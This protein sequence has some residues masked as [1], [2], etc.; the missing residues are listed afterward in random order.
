MWV[1]TAM[2]YQ[3]RYGYGTLEAM[4]KLWKEGGIRRF[5]R[6]LAPALALGPLSRFGDVA[7]NDFVISMFELNE[8]VRH[9]PM[10]IKTFCASNIAGL[11]R[12]F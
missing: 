4:Q 7:A 9:Y 2:N 5:Y 12:I 6:G 1:E 11:W 10:V 8:K 3:Y